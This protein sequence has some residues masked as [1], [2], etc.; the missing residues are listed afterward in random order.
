MSD[1]VDKD[2]DTRQ[3]VE[4]DVLIQ[5]KKAAAASGSEKGY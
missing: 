4:V 5:R 3:F 2:Q 1:A